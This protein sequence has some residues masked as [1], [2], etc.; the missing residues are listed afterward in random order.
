MVNILAIVPFAGSE[1]L[2]SMTED[3]IRQLLASTAAIGFHLSVLAVNNKAQRNLN[4]DE[5]IGAGK[6]HWVD[7]IDELEMEHNVGFGEAINRGI[8]YWEQA[9][10]L[11][12]DFYLLVNNDLQFPDP[13]WLKELLAAT[14]GRAICSPCT[15][16][17]ATPE[18]TADGR[19]N[20]G[21]IRSAQVSA[22]CWLVPSIVS[23]VLTERFGWAMF[24]PMFTNYG[25]DD[26]TAA[27]LRYI[28]GPKPFKVVP[29]SWVRHLKAQ[30]ARQF[31]IRAGDPEVLKRLANW[32]RANKLK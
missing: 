17:T 7:E 13:D 31:G 16:I 6:P 32:K 28:Y 8:G 4:I 23:R 14:E 2:V 20:A 9:S 15:D 10:A 18:A 30:T 11:K 21:P 3:C 26:A 24:P 12:P 27:A 19:R 25:S 29:R 22:F 5:C 1:S